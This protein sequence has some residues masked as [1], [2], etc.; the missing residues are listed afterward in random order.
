MDKNF[1]L[2]HLDQLDDRERT[3]FLYRIILKVSAEETAKR[4]KLPIREIQ[5][6]TRML[7]DQSEL[8]LIKGR[9]IEAYN[10]GV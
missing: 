10:L 2:S 5:D 9:L 3:I 8:L 4:L 6:T 1:Y 7:R